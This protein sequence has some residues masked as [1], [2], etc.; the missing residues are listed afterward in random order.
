MKTLIPTKEKKKLKLSVKTFY[1]I[2][3]FLYLALSLIVGLFVFLIGLSLDISII[4][5]C[6]NLTLSSFFVFFLLV[7]LNN[8]LYLRDKSTFDNLILVNAMDTIDVLKKLKYEIS[9]STEQKVFGSIFH[10]ESPK[11]IDQFN[12]ECNSDLILWLASLTP[13]Q[14]E[15]V[16]RYFTAL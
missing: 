13:H 11:L 16:Y 7:K 1:G 9:D 8:A 15:K 6:T 3:V 2:E 10:G 4:N 14:R 5:N 12:S